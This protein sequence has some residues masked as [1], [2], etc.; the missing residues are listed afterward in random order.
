MARCLCV[1]G[2]ALQ[3]VM[4]IDGT[5]LHLAPFLAISSGFSAPLLTAI[6]A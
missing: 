4:C 6:S 5:D 3:D 2:S 1:N